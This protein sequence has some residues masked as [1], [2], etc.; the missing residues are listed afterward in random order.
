MLIA[1]LGPKMITPFLVQSL[2][3]SCHIVA[4]QVFIVGGNLVDH[5]IWCQFDDT[6][7][8]GLNKFVVMRREED[9]SFVRLQVVVECLDRFQIQVVGRSIHWNQASSSLTT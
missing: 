7:G 8:N 1:S 6:V 4:V 9:I 2:A 5:T 3:F